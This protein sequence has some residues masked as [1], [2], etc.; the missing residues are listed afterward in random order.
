MDILFVLE[1]LRVILLPSI[2]WLTFK[3]SENYNRKLANKV[4]KMP[5]FAR[6]NNVLKAFEITGFTKSTNVLWKTFINYQ[7]HYELQTIH[8]TSTF[9][10]VALQSFKL[11]QFKDL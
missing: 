8:E 3:A 9:W 10:P 4:K 7:V 5:N 11:T 6:C 2:M 1:I